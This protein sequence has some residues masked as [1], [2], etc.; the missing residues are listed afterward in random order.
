M[1][2][3]LLFLLLLLSVFT[4]AQIS[5][6]GIVKDKSTQTPLPYATIKSGA[7]QGTITDRDGKFSIVLPNNTIDFQVSYIGYNSKLI[8]LEEGTTYYSIFLEDNIE[9]L[10]EVVLYASEDPALKIMRKVIA[11]KPQ[12]NPNK[13]LNT[14]RFNSYNRLIVTA[15][16]DSIKGSI[17]SIFK[18]TESGKKLIQVDSTNYE[19]K[20]QMKRAH[21]F[22]SEKN[23]EYTYTKNKGNIETVH[24]T[25]TSGLKQPIY[26]LLA[27]QLQSFSFYENQ[28]TVFGTN[29]ISPIGNRALKEYYYRILDTVS[30]QNREAYMIHYKPKTTGNTAGLEGVLYIDTNT[31]ALQ[32]ALVQLKAIVD[33]KATQE[34]NYYPKENLWF[35]SQ[36]EIILRKGKNNEAISMFG[37]NVGISVSENTK[38]TSIVRS[39]FQDTSE[40][41]YLK[42]TEHI[43][44][45]EFEIP[46]KIKG[47]GLALVFDDD[48]ATRT[49]QYWEAYRPAINYRDSGT[50]Y[51]LDSISEAQKIDTK[52]AF[53]QKLLKGYIN[54]KYIDFDLK[55]LIK[56]NNY[57]GFRIGMG[58]V[59]NTTLSPK[60]RLN[61]YG[62]YGT[63]DK[64]FKYGIGGSTKLSKISNTWLGF[65][66]IDDLIETGSHTYITEGRSFSLFE[67]RLFNISM[68]HKSRS[69]SSYL[70]HDITAK[71]KTKWQITKANISPT[72]PYIYTTNNLE[73][74][75]YKITTATVSTEWTPSS[76]YMLSPKGKVETTIGYPRI[77]FQVTQGIDNFLDGDFNFTKINIKALHQ[78]KFRN[79]SITNLQLELGKAFG[80]LPLSELFHTSP[81]NPNK[82]SIMRRFAVGGGNSFETMYFNEFFSDQFTSLQIKHYFNRLTI[83]QKLKPQF[84]FVTRAAIGDV[85]NIDKHVGVSFQSLRHGYMETGLEINK[86]WKGFGLA[87]FYRYG[88]YHL[89]RFDNNISL[90]FTY[91]FNLGL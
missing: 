58:F 40:L 65:N 84:V 73:Y 56:Y 66:Y 6:K 54:T 70:E 38:D 1:N 25:R 51:F 89:P 17:D 55:N 18:I 59:T 10:K 19:F 57:E 22:I 76:Q 91:F 63:K 77:S 7:N 39:D 14:Y 45:V 75:T 28:Y 42:S 48:A 35:P 11:Q 26:E 2:K 3:I 13:K 33:I 79:K 83:S 8:T 81:N 72:Y 37:K 15:E 5:I 9:N 85:D 88:A 23:S 64:Q 36:K 52:L 43:T 20:K 21:L 49:D 78:I 34:F 62:V 46:V 29:Y 50:Y 80:D 68:F 24:A 47:S 67:P 82:T 86:V 41:L 44:N 53:V 27:I 12:N 4:N 60:Y 30:I 90:K 71:L 31:Y 74:N 87:A 32:K 16:P 69:I 61:G